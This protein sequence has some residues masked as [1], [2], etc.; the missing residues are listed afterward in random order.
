MAA[1]EIRRDGQPHRAWRADN[2]I[3][4]AGRPI[5]RSGDVFDIQ[6]QRKR[7]ARRERVLQ[8]LAQAQINTGPIRQASPW[9]HGIDILARSMGDAPINRQSG[10]EG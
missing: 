8:R 3:V 5:M 6:A 1:S 2:Q 4:S 9:Q 7:L 10:K